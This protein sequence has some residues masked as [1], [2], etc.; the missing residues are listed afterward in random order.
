MYLIK[1]MK[2]GIPYIFLCRTE[3]TCKNP[4]QNRINPAVMGRIALKNLF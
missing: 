3:I 2:E 1:D 4:L